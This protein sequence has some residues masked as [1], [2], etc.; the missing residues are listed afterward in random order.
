MSGCFLP[1]FYVNAS[2]PLTLGSQDGLDKLADQS[3]W[4]IST[5]C[6][7]PAFKYVELRIPPIPHCPLH[8]VP[9]ANGTP[10]LWTVSG[11]CFLQ[12][13]RELRSFIGAGPVL[14]QMDIERLAQGAFNIPNHPKPCLHVDL[15]EKTVQRMVFKTF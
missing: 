10:S 4:T 9:A 7:S 6:D 13:H 2:H 8:I 14:G 1:D 11:V 12:A 5:F 3:E 15:L